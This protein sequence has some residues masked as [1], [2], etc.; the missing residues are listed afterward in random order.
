M[1]LSREKRA[2][3]APDRDDATAGAVW[4]A[5]ERIEDPCS[6]ASGA[7]AGLVSM[8]L[9]RT[10]DVEGPP[11]SA[12]VDVTLCITE[13]GCLMAA[14]FKKAAE[15]DLADLPGV[16]EVEVQV[17]HGYI[18]DPSDMAEPYRERLKRA[19]AERLERMKA[20]MA[21]SAKAQSRARASDDAE[22]PAR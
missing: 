11:E 13:P 21:S 17:D 15:R 18:W 10:V 22:R 7:P 8:G 14:V 19:R 5:L 12:R 6:V 1:A 20:R 16:A 3:A 2:L 4:D 9:V